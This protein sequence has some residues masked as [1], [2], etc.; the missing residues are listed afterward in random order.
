MGPVKRQSLSERVVDGIKK[1]I[2]EKGLRPGDRLP[3]EQEM[4]KRFAVSRVSVREATKALGFLG[5]IDAAPRRGL[6]VGQVDMRRVTQ[7][8]GFHL[9]LA[10]YPKHELLQTRIVIESGALIYISRTMSAQPEVHARLDK[11]NAALRRSRDLR[12]RIEHDLAFHRALLEA[13]GIGPLLV[14]NDLLQIFFDRF[15]ESLADAE[16]QKAV[17]QHQRLIDSL[18]RGRLDE[19]R[20]T[21]LEHLEYHN[22]AV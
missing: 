1:L 8:L 14:F 19:A 15:R 6:T 4:A 2:V 7:Y 18:A 13:S 21:L 22:Q 17:A 20:D 12:K 10:D 9:A 5:I 11:L 3:T 16:W